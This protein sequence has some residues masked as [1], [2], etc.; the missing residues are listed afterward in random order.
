LNHG[1]FGA[2]P[3]AVLLAQ[4]QIRDRM[5]REPVQFFMRDLEPLLDSARRELAAFIGAESKDLAFVPNATTG[6]NTV[7]SSLRFRTGDELLTTNHAYNACRNALQ[8]AAARTGAQVTVAEVP[9]PIRTPDEA[10]E[11]VM[12]KVTPRTRLVLLDH[13]SSPTA[14]VMPI[15]RI[16]AALNERGID[17]LVDGAHAPGML[18]LDLRSIGAAYYTGN[19][20]KWVC[21]PKGA[22]FLYVREDRQAEIHP[23]SI[24]HGMNATAKDRSR[25][26]LEFDWTGT[27]DFSAYLCIP[28]AIRFLAGL[29]P[30]GWPALIRHNH[31]LAIAARNALCEA[32][33][34]SPPAPNDMLGSMA[35]LPI[36]D[37]SPPPPTSSLTVDPQQIELFE[38]FG[39]EVPIVPWP[40]PPKRLIRV[41][42]Q[43]YNDLSDYDRLAVAVREMMTPS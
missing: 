5:E 17:A 1:S 39:V 2:C 27:D 8:F 22:A 38:R 42:A 25:F 29:L 18:P 21:A 28:E 13:V 35:A 15:A 20:H 37:G 7:L 26:R 3:R 34:V 14:L 32:W 31:E 43:I 6:V 36:W 23:L 16:V 33:E 11:Q 24:S 4:Q 30:G 12:A 41:S 9:F 40:R 10:L 19:C